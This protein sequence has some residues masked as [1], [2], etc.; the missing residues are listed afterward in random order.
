[1]QGGNKNIPI[2]QIKL[3]YTQKWQNDHW[4]AITSAYNKS[5]FFEYYESYIHDIIF[6]HHETLLSLNKDI[7]SFCLKVLN[8]E[9][10]IQFTKKF[11][12]VENN[13]IEDLRSRIHPKKTYIYNNSFTDIPYQQLF[14]NK[15]AANLSVLDLISCVGPDSNNYL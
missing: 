5:P 6:K 14:G 9:T 15:F 12:K 8:I 1:M 3:D 7:L 2:D 13:D 10:N 4:R 11:I